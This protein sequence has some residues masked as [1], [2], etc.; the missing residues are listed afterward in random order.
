MSDEKLDAKYIIEDHFDAIINQLDIHVEEAIIDMNH[1]QEI[2]KIN[3]LRS[4][5]LLEISIIKDFNLTF[6]ASSHAELERDWQRLLN[7]KSIRYSNKLETIKKDLIKK[8][9][10][11]MTNSGSKSQFS[12]WILNSYSSSTKHVNF[13]R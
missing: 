6:N 2:H 11:L 4:E 9:C 8:D 3:K 12:I 13:L 1:E 7:N 10:I 5:L